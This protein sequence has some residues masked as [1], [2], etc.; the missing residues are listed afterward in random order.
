MTT[1]QSHFQGRGDLADAQLVGLRPRPRLIVDADDRPHLPGALR[2]RGD[3]RCGDS[4]RGHAEAS[5][6][7]GSSSPSLQPAAPVVASS[8]AHFLD[9]DQTTDVLSGS[10]RTFTVGSGSEAGTFTA[11]SVND[12]HTELEFGVRLLA[13]G[14]ASGGTV[15]LR[16][17]GLDTYAQ[18]P[19]LIVSD[20]STRDRVRLKIGDTD[21][22]TVKL[23]DAEIDQYVS[24]WPTTSTSPPPTRPRASRPPTPTGSTSPRTVR[25]ST[26]RQRVEHYMTLA[27]QLRRRGGVDPRRQTRPLAAAFFGGCGCGGRATCDSHRPATWEFSINILIHSNAPFTG[28]GNATQTGLFV[29]LLNE[30]HEVRISAFFG[31]EGA[32]M[33]WDD[34]PAP[35]GRGHNFG[36]TYIS[37]ARS[38]TSSATAGAGDAVGRCLRIFEP[39]VF[40]QFACAAWTPV[41]R[42]PRSARVAGFFRRDWRGPAGDVEVRDGAVDEF[43]LIY[44]PHGIRH[45]HLPAVRG[46]GAREV[47]GCPRTLTS[48]DLLARTGQSE[49]QVTGLVLRRR[50]QSSTTTTMRRSSTWTP[51][52]MAAPRASTFPYCSTR[53]RFRWSN[54][55]A[56]QYRMRFILLSR[57]MTAQSYSSFDVLLNPSAGEGFS[58][59]GSSRRRRARFGYRL[60]HDRDARSLG[61]RPDG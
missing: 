13:A 52:F 17:G 5:Y 9:A 36:N 34:V 48:A 21:A 54:W 39:D 41:D 60:Q 44:V 53:S 47:P 58:V 11:V 37:C 45:R 50:S 61:L 16:V 51:K 4:A 7:G 46:R 15:A 10:G 33:E 6:G 12:S 29:P 38:Q 56:D 20:F 14:V 57:V 23:S 35:S 42:R 27:E 1:V 55:F 49:P 8:S 22:S 30:H 40:R 24:E 32:A 31:L 59:I 3:G 18:Y 2:D 26:A 19:L 28:T 25:R 43:E